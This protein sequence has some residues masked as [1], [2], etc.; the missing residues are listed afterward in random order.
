MLNTYSGNMF[1]LG[2]GSEASK[3][4]NCDRTNLLTEPVSD[5]S[6]AVGK[7]NW[8]ITVDGYFTLRVLFN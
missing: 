2:L 3:I 4:D 1:Y 7:Q 6:S 8:Q 5:T